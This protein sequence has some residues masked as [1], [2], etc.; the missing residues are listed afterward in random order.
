MKKLHFALIGKDIDYSRSPK[1]HG[2]LFQKMETCADYTLVNI[3]N[4][5]DLQS[6][7]A[8][9]KSNLTYTGINVTIPFKTDVMS[10][11]DFVS[12][13]AR[14]IGA[15]NTVLFSQED[16]QVVSKGYNTDYLGF[17]HSLVFYDIDVTG[18]SIAILG[19]GGGSKAVTKVL[20]DLGARCIRFVSRDKDSKSYLPHDVV[21]YEDFNAS[22]EQYYMIINCTPVGTSPNMGISPLSKESIRAEVLYDLIYNPGETKFLTYG[23][24]LGLK[25]I[26]GL[27]MLHAQAKASQDIWFNA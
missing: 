23:E 18:K 27:H 26:N 13:E 16:G 6:F 25:T 20:E 2:D 19:T 24:E 9:N 4:T 7:I 10:L 11:L 22:D 8:D 21:S 1:L 5:H 3:E 17:K 14:R 15:V 12:D